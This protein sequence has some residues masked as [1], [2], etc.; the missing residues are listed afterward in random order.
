MVLIDILSSRYSEFEAHIFDNRH[1]IKNRLM[2]LF[3][4]QN[5]KQ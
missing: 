1:N 2:E 5:D 3:Y 4:Y